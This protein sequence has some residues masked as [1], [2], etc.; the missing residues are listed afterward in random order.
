MKTLFTLLIA[1]CLQGA[2]Y[3]QFTDDFTDGDFTSNPAWT[4]DGGV[5][6]VNTSNQ[7]QLNSSGDGL[8]ILASALTPPSGEI[9]WRF[10]IKLS[11]SP[12]DNNLARVYLMSNTSDFRGD[13]NGYYLKFGETGSL[14]AIELVA[15]TGSTSAVVCRGTDGLLASSFALGVKV[16]RKANGEWQVFADASGGT[17][18]GLQASGTHTGI[19]N[20]AYLGVY[21]KYTSSNSTKFYFDDFYAGPPVADLTPPQALNVS[22]TGLSQLKVHFSEN[23]G[24]VSASDVNNYTVS[25]GG[26][27]PVSATLNALAASDVDLVFGSP[28]AGQVY[29]LAMSGVQD[30]AG[31]VMSPASL[32]FSFY[33]AGRFDVLIDEIMAD[34]SP[35]V[36]LPDAEYVE[37]YNRST[38]P[39]EMKNWTLNLNGTVKL[40]PDYT[41]AAGGFVILCDDANKTAL[42]PYGNVL[43]FSSFALTNAG[44][45]LVLRSASG[46]LIHAVEYSDTWYQS[47]YKND[48][49][50]SLE[51]IDPANPCGTSE[52]WVASDD[53][54]GGTPGQTNS[55]HASKADLSRPVITRIGTTDATHFTVYLSESCDSTALANTANYSLIPALGIGSAVPHSPGFRSVDLTLT[56]AVDAGVFYQLTMNE[57]ITDC[58]GN[59]LDGSV[60]GKLAIPSAIEANDIILNEVLF[61]PVTD[62]V[63]F[64]EVWNVSDKVLDLKDLILANY[65]TLTNTITNYFEISPT[66][67]LVLPSEYYVLST[68][69]AAVTHFYHTTNPGGF[70]DVVAMPTM[71]NDAGAIAIALKGGT[72]IDHMSYSASDHFPLLSSVDG[73]SLERISP[74]RPATDPGNWH[75]AASTVGYATPAYQNS[76]FGELPHGEDALTLSPEIFSPDEDGYNDVLQIAY[77]F[78]QM[79]N[80]LTIKVFDVQGHLVRIL[81]NNE[82]CGTQGAFSWDGTTDDHRKAAIGRYILLADV[83]DLNGKVKHY[84]YSTVLGGKL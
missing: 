8:S 31:N 50:W 83:F 17:N 43:E 27:H 13:L 59:A 30:L 36:G 18:Y 47:N 41:L 51:M 35:V 42:Q 1:L 77:H 14:D 12:S 76:Q 60:V 24:S 53:N 15:Q 38:A 10:W 54:L 57:G 16:L 69:S 81:V 6:K 56:T 62:G 63:D 39:I 23:L 40:I 68:D 64:V 45:T 32:P 46:T 3:A 66:S 29:Q 21:C 34:P 48:G 4:G 58:C 5:F 73:V 79:G 49:G 37:L 78:D 25:P 52:N 61:D 20:G 33:S 9:E 72:P 82:M 74:L 2:A 67:F 75:S 55:V 44:G 26:I 80:T 19:A 11:F 71:N 28:F 7:L 22:I 65:D 84:K 70:V